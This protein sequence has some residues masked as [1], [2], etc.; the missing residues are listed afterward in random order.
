[1]NDKKMAETPE[2]IEFRKYCRQWL[3]NNPPGPEPP[4]TPTSADRHPTQE[5]MDYLQAWQ[6]SAYKGG[7]VGCDYPV[8]Y[9]GGGRTDCQRIANGEMQRART[10]IFMTPNA[11]GMGTQTLLLHGSEYLKKR[12]I[13]KMLSAE[14]LWCQGFSEPDAGSDLANV[15]TFAEGKGDNWVINGQKIWTTLAVYADWMILLCRT[16]RSQK[17]AGLSYFVVPIKSALGEGVEVRPLIKMTGVTGFNEVFFTDLTV[18]DKYRVDEVGKGWSVA[19]TT[20]QH[21]RG[22]GALVTPSAGGRITRAE[23]MTRNANSLID[24][25]K[26]SLRNGKPASDDPVIRDGIM[27]LVIRQKGSDMSG[28]LTGVKGLA[29]H[30]MRIPMQG[31]VVGSELN[32]DI[33][34]FAVDIAGA[35]STLSVADQHAPYEGAWTNQY[36]TSYGGTIAAGTSEI[37]RNQLGE[38]VLGMPKTK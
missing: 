21:E 30:P 23:A 31:K 28:R 9:G 25:A 1:M 3:K 12:F 20:L 6:T 38:R 22:A 32:Q 5:Q 35:A 27:K 16:D 14:E 8:E 7:L 26:A 37:Q 19:M 34:G 33:A 17:H 18:P 13:P 10:P 29:D 2:Q 36:L 24:L 15:Q 11:L 4:G